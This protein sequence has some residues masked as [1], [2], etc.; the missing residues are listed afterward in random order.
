MFFIKQNVERF[1]WMMTALFPPECVSLEM[2]LSSERPLQFLIWWDMNRA[3]RL[4]SI[5]W[6][7]FIA[8]LLTRYQIQVSNAE[9]YLDLFVFFG[10][11]TY[12]NFPMEVNAFQEDDLDVTSK[13]YTK[14]DASTFLRSSETGIIDQV[15]L[16]EKLLEL[17]SIFFCKFLYPFEIFV[18]YSVCKI[19]LI[20]PLNYWWNS[21][22]SFIFSN[23][24]HQFKWVFFINFR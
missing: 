6:T 16:V 2:T 4:L 12:Q 5:Y 7:I 13:R 15:E 17:S 8:K 1:S 10:M 18:L 21:I 22:T 23:I 3:F 24:S 19:F 9:I 20:F 11:W 14:R